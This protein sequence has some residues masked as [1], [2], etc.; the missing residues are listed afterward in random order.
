M[1]VNCCRRESPR[2]CA[3]VF[4][5][6]MVLT[7]T[8]SHPS[9]GQKGTDSWTAASCLQHFQAMHPKVYMQGTLTPFS[10]RHVGIADVSDP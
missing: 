4:R 7:S 1:K 5:I 6:S 10:S 3:E 2:L 8:P 9:A